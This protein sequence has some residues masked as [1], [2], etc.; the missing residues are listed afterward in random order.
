MGFEGAYVLSQLLGQMRDPR[1][2]EEVLKA[3]DAVRR[4]RTQKIVKTSRDA[5]KL[6]NFVLPGVGSDLKKMNE[7]LKDWHEWIW[8]IDLPGQV[9][10]A[11]GMLEK[12]SKLYCIELEGR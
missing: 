10:E 1:R 3:Y 11:Q 5:G 6:Y 8:K 2:V 12:G 7:V 4:P 9:R